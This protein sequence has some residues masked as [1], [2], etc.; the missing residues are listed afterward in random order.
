MSRITNIAC[1]LANG[2]DVRVNLRIVDHDS[3][4]ID[5]SVIDTLEDMLTGAIE[6]ALSVDDDYTPVIWEIIGR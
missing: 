6:D 4:G 1:T 5:E 3:G 2:A